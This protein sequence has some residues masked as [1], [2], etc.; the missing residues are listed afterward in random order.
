MNIRTIITNVVIL[1]KQ[2]TKKK[3]A[4]Y[5]TVKFVNFENREICI[6]LS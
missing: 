6:K 2:N 3:E 4:G 1:T 5:P